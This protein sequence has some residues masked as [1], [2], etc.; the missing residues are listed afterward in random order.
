[1]ITT[2]VRHQTTHTP[3]NGPCPGCTCTLNMCIAGKCR[4][5]CCCPHKTT[6]RTAQH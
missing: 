5:R 2:R 4:H 6:T 3:L 1:M